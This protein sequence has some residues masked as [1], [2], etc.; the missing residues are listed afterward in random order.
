MSDQLGG[1]AREH[2]VPPPTEP[3]TALHLAV[4]LLV[5][6]SGAVETISFIALDHVFAGVMTSN[7]ALLGMAIGRGQATGVTATV[8]ALTGFA[9]GA[10]VTAR[11]TR[12]REDMLTR[13]A[14]PVMFCLAGEAV[15]LAVGAGTWAA[16]GGAPGRTARDALQFGAAAAMG[17][18]SAAMV[19]A[20]RAASPT[21]YLTGTLATYI[22]KGVGGGRRDR[23]VPVQ[24]AAL[25]AGAGASMAVLRAAPRWTGVLPV[26]LVV[27]AILA[28]GM[29][30]IRMRRSSAG[31]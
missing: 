19:A 6:A 31:R 24:L 22:V 30:V 27:C 20:G 9:L 12:R 14:P 8:L 5:A 10:A 4:V 1:Q 28:A 25:M 2:P 29:P 17:I 3:V 7:L 18:Q 23:W 21:T 26:V 16:M 13:W 15:V 11:L